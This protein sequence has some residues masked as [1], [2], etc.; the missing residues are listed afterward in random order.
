MIRLDTVDPQLT[1]L[2]EALSSDDQR[3]LAVECARL[4]VSA[5]GLTDARVGAL[6][7]VL[8]S[9]ERCDAACLEELGSLVNELD[10]AQWELADAVDDG[11]A[12]QHEYL[13]AFGR[14]R[15]ANAVLCAAND[16]S[17]IA[18]LEAAYE[19]IAAIGDP[20]SVWQVA[21]NSQS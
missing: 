11:D 9:P 13:A 12:S 20:A 3:T 4:A 7:T 19:A 6:L 2:I 1:G 17:K 16:D 10:S 15:A 18:A 14:A 5:T 21:K 8:S